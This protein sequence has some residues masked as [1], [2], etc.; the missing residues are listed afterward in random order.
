MTYALYASGFYPIQADVQ[1][2]HILPTASFALVLAGAVLADRLRRA[3]AM[4]TVML[5]RLFIGAAIT[6]GLVQAFSLY[7]NARRYAVGMEGR[8]WFLPTSQWA[9]PGGWAVWLV[10]A[11]AGGAA[12]TAVVLAFRPRAGIAPRTE[13][14]TAAR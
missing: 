7:W 10:L 12:L 11:L 8:I 6:A 14:A 4:G 5:S 9:P 1:G 2:R 3:G 13:H